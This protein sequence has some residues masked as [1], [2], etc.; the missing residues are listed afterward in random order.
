MARD[1]RRKRTLAS[2]SYFGGVALSGAT[3]CSA[4]HSLVLPLDVIKTRMQTDATAAA[5]GFFAASRALLSNAPGSGVFR[6]AA[7]FNGL[8]PTAL[9][10]F[11]QGATK[12]GGYELLKQQTFARLRETGGESAVS[13]W[14]LPVMLGSAATAEMA[15]TILLAPLEVLKLRMQTDPSA[16]ARGVVRTFAQICRNEGIGQLYVGLAPIAM[17]Q[18]PYTTAKLVV[19]ELMSRGVQRLDGRDERLRACATALAGLVAGAAS[20]IVSHPADLLLTRLCGSATATITTNVAECVIA[21]GFA[22]QV[23]Y[24]MSLGLRGA[25]AGIGPRLLMTAAMTSLQFSIYEAVR[26]GLGVMQTPPPAVLAP[27]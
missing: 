10:Y 5:G 13:K 17:R 18:L 14:Q 27:A 21:N 1:E 26:S 2:L 15:A 16:A 3:A 4:T 23:R 11:L 22:D 25:Y 8:P 9:G 20:A 6:L 12:F 19:Y 7:F 24:L